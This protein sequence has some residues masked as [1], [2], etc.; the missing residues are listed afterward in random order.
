MGKQL[1]KPKKEKIITGEKSSLIKLGEEKGYISISRDGSEI[2]YVASKKTYNFNDPEEKVRSR[3][4]VELITKYKYLKTRID[5]EVYADRREPKLPADIVI[6]ED[7]EFSKAFLVVECKAD[8]SEEKI[9]EAKREGLGNATLQK[10][11]YLVVE[12]G[13]YR[14]V[15]DLSKE[16]SLKKLDEHII[17]D[18][19][20]SYDKVPEYRFKK[21]DPNNDLGEVNFKELNLLFQKC[22]NILWAGGKRDPA[23]AFDEM[24]KLMFTKLSDERNTKNGEVYNFQIGTHESEEI[25]AKRVKEIYKS[26]RASDPA[27]FDKEL[28]IEDMKIRDIVGILQGVSLL[29]TDLDA[30]GRA[31][32]Q[33][34]SEVFRGSLG[35]YFT[36]RE[37]VQF[38]IQMM[39]PTEKDIILDPA[40]GSGGFLLYALK[41]VNEDIEKDYTGDSEIIKRKQYDFSHFNL[42]GIEINDKIARVAMMDM[43]VHDDGH[44]NI[45]ENTAL[46]SEFKNSAIKF[47]NFSLILTNPPFGDSVK[48]DDKDKLGKNNLKNFSICGSENPKSEK[49]EILFLERCHDFLKPNGRMGI[50]VPDGILNN[51]GKKYTQVREWLFKHFTIL[52]IISLP[53][54][55]F[56]QSGAG[57]RTSLLFVEKM[58]SNSDYKIFLGVAHKIGYNAVGKPTQNELSDIHEAYITGKTNGK[59]VLWK[60][61]SEIKNCLDPRHYDPEIEKVLSKIKNLN[62]KN[63]IK[64]FKL[65]DLLDSKD[66]RA[67]KGKAFDEQLQGDVSNGVSFLEIKNITKDG[68]IF[69]EGVG[70]MEDKY[71]LKS[72]IEENKKYQLL[73]DDIVVAITGATIGKSGLIAKQLMPLSF[74]GDIARLRINKKLCDPLYIDSFLQSE[75]GQIQIYKWINGATNL[76]LA[77]EAIEEIIVPV[78]PSYLDKSKEIQRLRV[79]IASLNQKIETTRKTEKDFFSTLLTN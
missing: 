36:R 57:I 41:K 47:G 18:I 13:S 72:W 74:S 21:H 17:A 23:I 32:E 42:L 6:Y 48:K 77:T 67:Q 64:V 53:E 78:V 40:C 43:I 16:P 65:K 66:N 73:E 75:L 2:T 38:A 9:R 30:K 76:H 25:V 7:N 1:Y 55:T 15:F 61:L 34:L 50:V 49:P 51:P 59:S 8:S 60:K 33:F 29:K 10:V 22:H 39:S 58:K 12:C 52:A 14:R 19:P 46:D 71:I 31:F 4:Y 24:S 11:K 3:V 37:I 45:E 68:V 35:Q 79:D 56:K 62:G 44:T 70:S 20:V 28:E 69:G 54:F 26:A 63:K 5:T 27:V